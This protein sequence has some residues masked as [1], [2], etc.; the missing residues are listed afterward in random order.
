MG[1]VRSHL[2]VLRLSVD[3]HHAQV[4]VGDLLVIRVFVENNM[5]VLNIRC[6]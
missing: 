4:T 1:G 2:L 5:H 6:S 3:V